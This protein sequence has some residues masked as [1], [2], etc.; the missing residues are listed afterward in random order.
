[1]GCIWFY[2]GFTEFIPL[3]W[4]TVKA[5]SPLYPLNKIALGLFNFTIKLPLNFIYTFHI[6]EA[7]VFAG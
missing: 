3:S 2:Q 4:Y 5:Q 7:F 6:F 1:M